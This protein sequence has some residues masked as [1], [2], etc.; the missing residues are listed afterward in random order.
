M[1][2]INI[3]ESLTLKAQL[4]LCIM[5]QH[6]YYIIFTSDGFG[7]EQNVMKIIYCKQRFC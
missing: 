3:I 1:A 2:T 5:L 6:I 4:C 7:E